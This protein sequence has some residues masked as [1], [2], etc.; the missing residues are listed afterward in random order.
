MSGC[1]HIL[2][3]ALVLSFAA[4]AS[5]ELENRVWT[6]TRRQTF[7]GKLIEAAGEKA[8]IERKD[9]KRFTVAIATLSGNDQ[10]YVVKHAAD[11]R[12]APK[13]ESKPATGPAATED[14]RQ[15]R[16]SQ[17]TRG[18]L[19]GYDG[20][21]P[22]LGDPWPSVLKCDDKVEITV[23]KED[24]TAK[25]YIYESPHFRFQ[26]NAVMRKSLI[27]KIALLFEASYEWH[28]S[29]PLN[30]RR[31]RSKE[32]PKLQ[33]RLFETVDQY[34]YA[35]G[36]AGT[37]GVYM[38]GPDTFMVPFAEVGA[39]KV[40]SGY[41][42]D[43]NGDPHTMLH[44]LTHQL[45]ADVAQSSAIWLTEGFAE[46]M[47]CVP[48]RGGSFSYAG[49][50]RAIREYVMAYGKKGK[51]GRALG[52]HITM[53]RLEK[54]MAMTQPEFYANGNSNYGYGLMLTT[55]FIDMDEGKDGA[56]FKKAIQAMQDGKTPEEVNKV[57]LNGRNFEDLERDFAKAW[58]ACG[59]NIEF[60]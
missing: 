16:M 2:R 51:G 24:D 25:E 7:E 42:Y 47:G 27:S 46:Y 12:P 52:D 58:R 28:K 44:E 22:N 54:L 17:D 9:G 15:S 5:A 53:P 33:A 38:G 55:Y 3:C 37:A 57:L 48:Y 1:C 56:V 23:L 21:H 18:M 19:A 40:G 49:H 35:G 50:A 45:W 26:S 31:T 43:F 30:N 20:S 32:A 59:A 34:H 8:V 60:K 6:N 11:V 29:V 10:E 36:P 13:P 14:S 41:M 4:A 39:K